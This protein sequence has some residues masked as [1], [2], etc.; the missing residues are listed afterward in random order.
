MAVPPMEDKSSLLK[1]INFKLHI[2]INTLDCSVFM[3]FFGYRLAISWLCPQTN[4]L[5][6]IFKYYYVPQLDMSARN[7]SQWRFSSTSGLL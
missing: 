6:D 7:T 2:A 4:T 3:R 1:I 5:Q